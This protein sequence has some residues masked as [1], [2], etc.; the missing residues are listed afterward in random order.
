MAQLCFG[1]Q[2]GQKHVRLCHQFAGLELFQHLGCLPGQAPRQR[3]EFAVAVLQFFAAGVA[4]GFGGAADFQNAP[5]GGALMIHDFQ[6]P[7]FTSRADPFK[8]PSQHADAIG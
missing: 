8:T 5:L 7:R 1:L 4:Q 6:G 3:N 2:H